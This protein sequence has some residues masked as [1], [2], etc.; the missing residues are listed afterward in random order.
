VCACLLVRAPGRG[1]G[2]KG[3]DD[4]DGSDAVRPYTPISDNDLVGRFELLVKRYE[5]G[6]VS[7]YL[8][9]LR[10][11]AKV[12]SPSLRSDPRRR[13]RPFRALP[14]PPA[15]SSVPFEVRRARGRRPQVAFKHIK[16]N[17]KAQYPFAGKQS[18]TFLCAGTGRPHRPRSHADAALDVS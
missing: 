14:P 1:R 17:I 12:M 18:F 16:F 3:K 15:R 8:H 7:Q 4:W 6:A 9:G 2:S 5:G 13:N 10:L 11:G